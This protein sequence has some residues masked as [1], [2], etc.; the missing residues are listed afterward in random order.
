MGSSLATTRGVQVTVTSQHVPERSNP[1]QGMW[2]F[3][4]HITIE[5]QGAQTV[6]LLTRHWIIT[7]A[8]GRIEEVRG[9][10]VVGAQPVLAPGESFEYSSACPL[11]T[12]FGTMQG[13]Y[14]MVGQDGEQFDAEIAA[15]ALSVPYAVN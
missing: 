3:A 9:P 2:F 5:N 8:D 11:R 10:G 14:Q 15:F 1:E 12:P 6:Q 13:T 7:D 4:Y